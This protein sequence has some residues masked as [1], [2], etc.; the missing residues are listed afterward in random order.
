MCT[1]ELGS[2]S[3]KFPQL[4]SQYRRSPLCYTIVVVT[5]AD[6]AW[7]SSADVDI[8]DGFFALQPFGIIDT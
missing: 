1:G 6:L 4:Y 2:P 3:F 7:V 5:G 8:A